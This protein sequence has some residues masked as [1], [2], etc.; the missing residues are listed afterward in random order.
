MAFF[1]ELE[2]YL[3][4][5]FN[6]F[7]FSSS[8]FLYIKKGEWKLGKYVVKC[9]VCCITITCYHMLNNS[10]I[11]VSCFFPE[12]IW[13]IIHTLFLSMLLFMSILDDIN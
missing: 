2:E 10:S 8:F 11:L 6:N 9:A 1:S 5:C 3:K 4:L 12:G 13:N 7:F